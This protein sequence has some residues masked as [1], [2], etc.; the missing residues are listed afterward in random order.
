MV[1]NF[2][3]VNGGVTVPNDVLIK[4]MDKIYNATKAN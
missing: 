1:A 4:I 2:A 3:I